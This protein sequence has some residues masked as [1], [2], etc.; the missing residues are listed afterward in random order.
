[1]SYISVVTDGDNGTRIR[2]IAWGGR[3]SSRRATQGTPR[4]PAYFCG[5]GFVERWLR[6]AAVMTKQLRGSRN[7]R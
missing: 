2:T 1:M 5:G 6:E 4:R 3:I 7:G